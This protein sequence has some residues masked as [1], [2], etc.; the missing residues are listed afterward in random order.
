MKRVFALL[1][2]LPLLVT[3]CSGGMY[4]VILVDD[5]RYIVQTCDRTSN[6]T[7]SKR[8]TR[9]LAIGDCLVYSTL[10]YDNFDIVDCGICK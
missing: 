7:I 5:G 9:K 10:S 6:Y 3:A 4:R 1:I 8:T 2:L